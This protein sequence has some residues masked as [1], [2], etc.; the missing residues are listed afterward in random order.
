MAG[1]DTPAGAECG[2]APIPC[3]AA[4]AHLRTR[5]GERGQR[6]SKEGRTVRSPRTEPP[7]GTHSQMTCARLTTNVLVSRFFWI[8]RPWCA[9][10][11]CRIEICGSGVVSIAVSLTSPGKR[12]A[13]TRS[14]SPVGPQVHAQDVQKFAGEGVRQFGRNKTAGGAQH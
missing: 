5:A 13:P 10:G 7:R 2:S 6:L 1:S 3:A 14:G 12:H 8:V 11:P 9:P 4:R